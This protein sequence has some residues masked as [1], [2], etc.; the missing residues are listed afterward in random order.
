MQNDLVDIESTLVVNP[1]A[2]KGYRIFRSPTNHT[3][4][5]VV[6]VDKKDR[7]LFVV[8]ADLTLEEAQDAVEE[9]S[10]K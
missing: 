5:N 9:H 2:I 6:A 1:N 7:L 10:E 4:F 8:S 3:L